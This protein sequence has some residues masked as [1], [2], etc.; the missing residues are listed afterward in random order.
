MVYF[1]EL[2]SWRFKVRVSTSSVV[3][4][5]G[6]I[7]S[8]AQTTEV[9]SSTRETKVKKWLFYSSLWLAILWESP[10]LARFIKIS[11]R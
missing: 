6:P 8:I 1:L 11:W 4:S 9:C 5:P 3:W 2:L 7:Q 10:D